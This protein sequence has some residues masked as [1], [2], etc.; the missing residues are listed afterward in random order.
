MEGLEVATHIP[1][2]QGLDN[3]IVCQHSGHKTGGMGVH[4]SVATHQSAPNLSF[5]LA[6]KVFPK[7]ALFLSLQKLLSGKSCLAWLQHHHVA[8]F[9]CFF[10][11]PLLQ[12]QIQMRPSTL[13][14]DVKFLMVK[15]FH[16]SFCME[17]PPLISGC[18]QEMREWWAQMLGLGFLSVPA[19]CHPSSP[20]G[21]VWGTA[22]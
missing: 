5:H 3:L 18:I 12:H 13:F 4:G 8:A 1:C 19:G 15:C 2:S 9:P 22:I 14:Q 20:S 11:M 17:N 6:P 21:A 7:L 16:L 10:P